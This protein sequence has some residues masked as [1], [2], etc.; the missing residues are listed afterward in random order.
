MAFRLIFVVAVV[1]VIVLS[2]PSSSLSRHLTACY[3]IWVR[4][5]LMKLYWQGSWT[6]SSRKLFSTSLASASRWKWNKMNEK[7][8]SQLDGKQRTSKHSGKKTGCNYIW[9]THRHTYLSTDLTPFV[10]CDEK[11]KV[12][13][14]ES[15]DILNP[16]INL[17]NKLIFHS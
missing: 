10:F 16:P 5:Y 3:C 12:S 8:V 4:L 1:V 17:L 2:T 7:L 6:Q 11:E 15:Q 14:N 13:W 9:H